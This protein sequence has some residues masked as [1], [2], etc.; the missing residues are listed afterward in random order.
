MAPGRPKHFDQT[1]IAEEAE[2]ESLSVQVTIDA[3]SKREAELIAASLPGEP[4]ASA[5][6]GYGVI[7]LRFQRLTEAKELIPLI[8]EC[9][10][11]HGLGW[12]RVRIGDDQH[13]LRAR[14]VN[15]S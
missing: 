4:H 5:W 12:A 14:K 7:R 2:G 13:M 3:A 1:G 8:A 10:Q 11:Q 15:A 9:V 6:R